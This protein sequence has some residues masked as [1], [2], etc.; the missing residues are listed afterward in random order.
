MTVETSVDKFTGEI[1]VY[2]NVLELIGNTPLVR[3]PKLTRG[4]KPT[5]LAKIEMLNPGGSVK[6]R[7]G[8][9]MIEDAERRGLLRKGGTIIEPT[10]GNTGAG[11]AIAAAIKGYKAIFIMPDKM[12]QEKIA[13]LKAYGA[14]V[15]ITPTAVSHD[16]PEN[17]HNVADRL[18]REIPG[19]FQ[20]NQYFN[21]V[22][23]QTHYET[24]GPEIW[25]QTKGRIDYFVAGVG[26]GGTISGVARYLKE[27]NPN[28]KIVGVDPEGSIYTQEQTRPYKVEG[29]GQ[30]YIPGTLSMDLIDEW[31]TVSDRDSFL[32]ARRCVREEGILVGGSC[33]TALV[34]AF[35]A[36]KKLDESK[37]MVVL[38]PDSGRSYLSKI[39]NDAWMR[40][41]GFTERFPTHPQVRD[42]LH[43]HSANQPAPFITAQ[44]DESVSEAIARLHQHGISQMPVV[45]EK[46]VSGLTV[47]VGSLQERTLLEKIFKNPETVNQK[48]EQ[49]MDGP[50][51][52]VDEAEEIENII[53][54]FSPATAALVVEREGEPI[55]IISRSDLLEFIAQQRHH[56][57]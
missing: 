39:F 47:I 4:L 56:Q 32:M 3:M 6:D 44:A 22:N 1:E 15:I 30:D 23:P 40:D 34:G 9:K 26:T 57:I 7:I 27:Q 11:L 46:S 10:S 16:S 43:S 5:I 38:L 2:D 33:G 48:V 50:L 45:G 31:V 51:P 25:K 35:E 52:V 19:A 53:P 54:L 18:T 49:V 55:G 17:Y 13:L 41:Q 36:A 28:I 42:L 8:I 21:P 24:T 37:L 20:P 29:I 12:S 14:D